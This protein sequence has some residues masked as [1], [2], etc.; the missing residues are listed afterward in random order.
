M[1]QRF[2]DHPAPVSNGNRPTLAAAGGGSAK[3]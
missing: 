2:R 3:G 1:K